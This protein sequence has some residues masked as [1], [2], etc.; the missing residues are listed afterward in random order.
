MSKQTTHTWI[1]KS[2]RRKEDPR[3]LTGEGHFV[4]DFLFKG[5]HMAIFRSPVAHAKIRSIDLSRARALPGVVAAVSG[6]EAKNMWVKPLKPI[7]IDLD[8]PRY[9]MP[10]DKV[11]YVGEPLAAVAATSKAIAEDALELVDFDYEL[12]P[13]VVD[14]EKAMEPGAPLLY[15]Q[16]GSNVYNYKEIAYGDVDSAFRDAELVVKAKFKIPRYTSSPLETDALVASYQRSDDS[17]TITSN[18]QQMRAIA[19]VGPI[20]GVAANKV[21]FIHGDA[22]G[23]F[24]ERWHEELYEICIASLLSKMTEQPVKY[25]EDRRE[26]MLHSGSKRGVY[27]GELAVTGDGTIRALKLKDMTDEGGD[28][29]RAGYYNTIK[30][31]NITGLYR[32][33]A[34]R[35]HMYSLATNIAS[36]SS[37]RGLSKPHITFVLERLVDMVAD[38]LGVD[39]AELRMKNLLRPDELPHITPSGNYLDTGDYP[40]LLK[41]AMEKVDYEGWRSKQ[42][43]LRKEGRYIG[44]GIACSVD[45]GASNPGREFL[46]KKSALPVKEAGTASTVRIYPSGEVEVAIA[47]VNEGQGHETTVAQVVAEELGVSY[48]DIHVIP[49]FDSFSTAW[50]LTSGTGA[51]H[52]AMTDMGAVVGATRKVKAKLLKIAAHLLNASV[53]DLVVANGHVSVRGSTDRSLTVQQI[54]IIAYSETGRLPPGMEPG[55]HE[56][57]YYRPEKFA[58]TYP[59][60]SQGRATGHLAYG[61]QVHIS[62]VEVDP[63]TGRVELLRYVASHDCGVVINPNIVAGQFHGHVLHGIAITLGE[64][65]VYNEDGQLL[66]GTLMDYPKPTAVESHEL[67]VEHFEFPALHTVLGS[68]PVGEGPFNCPFAAVTNAI[69]D[70]L[71]PLNI[72]FTDLPITPEVIWRAMQQSKQKK[73]QAAA[74]QRGPMVARPILEPHRKPPQ[75]RAMAQTFAAVPPRTA[76]VGGVE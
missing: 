37:D 44:I 31:T 19:M 64:A 16:L 54:A 50:T 25:I 36:G 8:L 26:M 62:V 68:K 75:H 15:E 10:F 33:E 2:V 47:A 18:T 76:K 22:G 40:L 1:G 28:A 3:L 56:N 52:F 66:T 58:P 27:E 34:L 73:A 17:L 43:A 9:P 38:R 61:S 53:D 60:D 57:F 6:L 20:I 74:P 13:V 42:I 59:A 24:G 49:I 72:E 71:K 29:V 30:L 14:P 45:P 63:E 12:L 41:S 46:L 4:D 69:V 55:L 21:R 51:D 48:D 39:P 11:T 70:A 5:L 65:D 7:Y 32:I 23:S 67:E 35:S